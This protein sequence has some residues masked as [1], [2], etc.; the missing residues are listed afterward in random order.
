MVDWKVGQLGFGGNKAEK[1]G[2]LV[3]FINIDAKSLNTLL[4][5]GMQRKHENHYIHL[6]S[7]WNLSWVCRVG[8]IFENQL[9]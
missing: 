4:V 2:R 1:E 6:E 8:S 9:V 3:S 5:N 7:K